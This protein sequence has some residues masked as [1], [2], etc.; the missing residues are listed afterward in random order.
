MGLKIDERKVRVFMAMRGIDTVRDLARKAGIHE[1]TVWKVFKGRNFTAETLERLA[2][3][4]E[5]NPLDLLT[6]EGY[7]DPHMGAPALASVS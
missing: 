5:C 2:T 6:V 7:P 3:A 4:L 1:D